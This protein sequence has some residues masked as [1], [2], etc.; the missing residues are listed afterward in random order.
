MV[1]DIVPEAQPSGKAPRAFCGIL[2]G[3]ELGESITCK[4]TVE[5]RLALWARI[6]LD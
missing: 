5:E 4:V 6:S 3:A 1:C 2:A